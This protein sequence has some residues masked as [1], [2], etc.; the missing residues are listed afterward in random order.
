M[1]CE[2]KGIH[3]IHVF[4]D[5][6]T[7]KQEEVEKLLADV[8]SNSYEFHEDEAGNIVLPRSKFS[9]MMKIPGYKLAE[10]T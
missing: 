2:E 6:W 5:E 8:L 10:V 7:E 9:T 1:V 3:L 4:E